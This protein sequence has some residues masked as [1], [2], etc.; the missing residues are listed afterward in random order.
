MDDEPLSNIL[1]ISEC[2]EPI[3]LN[4]E[5]QVSASSQLDENYIPYNAIKSDTGAYDVVVVKPFSCS[6]SEGQKHYKWKVF[7]Y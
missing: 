3:P 6:E 5:C 7:N 2:Y 1:T 4:F